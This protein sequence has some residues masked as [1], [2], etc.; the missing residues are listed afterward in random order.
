MKKLLIAILFVSFIALPSAQDFVFG[1]YEVSTVQNANEGSNT[2]LNAAGESGATVGYI[3]LAN[4]ASGTRVCSSAGGCQIGL[5]VGSV[6][7]ANVASNL[8]LGFQDVDLTTGFEDGT[9]DVEANLVPGTEAIASNTVVFYSMESNSKTITPY[10]TPYAL[11]AELT[12]RAGA[13]SVALERLTRNVIPFG[14]PYGTG[15]TG[16]LARTFEPTP[17]IIKFDDGT[18]GWFQQVTP[19]RNFALGRTTLSVNT[20]TNPDEIGAIAVS[21]IG[22]VID[23]FGHWLNSVATTDTFEFAI[24]ENPLTTTPDVIWGPITVDP[25]QVLSDGI[26]RQCEDNLTILPNVEYGY[27]FKPTSVNSITYEF[28]TLPSGTGMAAAMKKAQF[29]T[30]IIQ[31]GR[32]DETGIFTETDALHLPSFFL[33]IVSFIETEYGNSFPALLLAP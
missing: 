11:V 6:T 29:F 19:S 27:M 5:P 14:F 7:W 18:I 30:S 1:P 12:A 28:F 24:Y 17:F 8:R 31:A 4:Q 33:H 32:I 23:C 3:W 16:A 22:M 2:T 25:D 21:P 26:V 9:F 13:D 15:D 10:T 20:G